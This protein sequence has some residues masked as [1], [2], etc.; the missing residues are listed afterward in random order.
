MSSLQKE[1]LNLYREITELKK[2]Y[3]WEL[4]FD[5]ALQKEY[6]DKMRRLRQIAATVGC[7]V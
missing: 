2:K 5:R 1:A 7:P 4:R 6:G 3:K